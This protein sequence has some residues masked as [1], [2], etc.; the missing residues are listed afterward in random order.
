[1][2]TLNLPRAEDI[3]SVEVADVAVGDSVTLLALGATIASPEGAL[4]V[5]PTVPENPLDP[6][7]VI[8]DTPED[9]E[10][11]VREEGWDETP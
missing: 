3:V 9:P 2:V 7:T 1:M 5:R 11:I 4:A 6:V 8:V 10:V